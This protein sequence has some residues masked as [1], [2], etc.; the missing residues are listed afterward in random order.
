MNNKAKAPAK[1]SRVINEV[2][3]EGR[4]VF[5]DLGFSEDE[6]VVLMTEVADAIAA[7]NAIKRTI[8][9][10]LKEQI[11]QRKLNITTAAEFL[12]ISRPRLSNIASARFEKFSIDSAVDLMLKFGKEVKVQLVDVTTPGT[13]QVTPSAGQPKKTAKR[14]K[15][16]QTQV[17]HA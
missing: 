2:V 13:T 16:A 3:Y 9:E 11:F 7:R 1:K 5:D 12:E 4:S 8:V 10:A 14:T 17:V 15:T 6:T